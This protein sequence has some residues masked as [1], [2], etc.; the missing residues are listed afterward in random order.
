MKFHQITFLNE[1]CMLVINYQSVAY[2]TILPSEAT[3]YFYISFNSVHSI[4]QIKK[5]CTVLVI[6]FILSIP[7]T[8]SVEQKFLDKDNL[9][10][11]YLGEDIILIK[12]KRYILNLKD[13]KNVFRLIKI[14]FF[15]TLK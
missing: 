8:F 14:Y 12:C 7:S 10:Q 1:T 11:L 5:L 4:R 6:F 3:Y 13:Y 15:L 2:K 9:I